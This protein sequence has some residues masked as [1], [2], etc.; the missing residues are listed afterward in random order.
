MGFGGGALI[1]CPLERPLL[2]LYDSGYDASD[3]ASVASGTAVAS[4]FVTLGIVYLAYMLFGAFTVRVP[5]DDWQPDGWDPVAGQGQ[6]DGHHG[7]RLRRQRRSGPRSSGC[8][9]SCCSAT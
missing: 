6:E 1:A 2:A 7:Q 5:A 8:C 4:L 9:G 3:P